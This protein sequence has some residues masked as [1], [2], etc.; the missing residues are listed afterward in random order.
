[1][2]ESLPP[3]RER[4]IALVTVLWALLFLS[5]L[6]LSLAI[7]TRTESQIGRNFGGQ[8]EAKALADAGIYRAI[9]TLVDPDRTGRWRGDGR[10]YSFELGEGIVRV[11]LQD[12]AGKIDLNTARPTLLEALFASAGLTAE[13]AQALAAS[14]EDWRDADELRRP[15]GAEE[16]EYR[17]AGKPYGPGN[18]PFETIE[19]FQLVLGVSAV[20]YD[21]VADR[22]TVLSGQPGIDPQ[23]APRSVLSIIPGLGEAS[24]AAIVEGRESAPGATVASAVSSPYFGRSTATTFTIHGE[25]RSK[26]GAVYSRDAVVRLTGDLQ[27]PYHVLRWKRGV[28]RLFEPA[29]PDA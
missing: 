19:E 26:A 28:R 29:E 11:S 12:E 18:R 7:A 5:T 25:G 16:P 6:A 2:N 14:V 22:L 3:R 23:I 17:A 1:V 24:A 21:Q 10:V 13:D 8:V 4:G 20:L 15:N 9:A 27:T